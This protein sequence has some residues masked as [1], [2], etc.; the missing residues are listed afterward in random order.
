[1]KKNTLRIALLFIS[2][3]FAKPLAFSQDVGATF[4][5][6][7]QEIYGGHRAYPYNN[8]IVTDN[9]PFLDPIP[10]GDTGD[11]HRMRQWWENM[12]EEINYSGLDFVA[13]LS[14]GNQKPAQKDNGNG[15]PLHIQKLVAA[16]T[17]RGA[18]NFKLAIFDDCPNSWTANRNYYL[19]GNVSTSPVFDCA[20]TAN[21]KYIW[22]NNLRQAIAAIPD[23]KRYKID[24]RM[25]I[26]FWSVKPTWMKNTQ[27]NLTKIL[28]HIRTKCQTEF[29]F[30]P[31]IIIDKDWL[32]NDTT[33]STATVDAVQGWF[34]VAQNVGYT[35]ETW[36]GKKTGA[37]CPGFG[38]PTEMAAYLDPGMGTTDMGKRLKYGLDNT[39]DAGA[40][41]TLVEGFTDSAEAAALWRSEDSQYYDYPNQRLNILRRYTS[42]PYP[43]TLKMEAEACDFN[44]DLTG[45]N[46]GGAFLKS[47]NLDVVDCTDTNG[48]WNVTDTQ[49]NEWMEWRELPLL[50]NTKFQLRY[51]STA[52]SSIKFSVDGTALSTISLPSTSGLWS[53]FDAGNYATASNS[54]HTVKLTIV[55]GSPDINY[56]TRVTGTATSTANTVKIV[57]AENATFSGA[58]VNTNQ[59]G[60]NGTGFIDFVNNSADYL[61]WTVNVPTAGTY[62]LSFRYALPSGGRQLELKVN[63]T[64]KI[65][66]LDF[67]ATATWST[68]ENLSTSQQ[69]VAGNNTIRLTTI[70]SNGGNFDELVVIPFLDTCDAIN[71]WSSAAANTLTYNTTD[72]KQGAGSVQMVGSATEEFKKVFS[73]AFNSGTTVANGVLSFWYFIS[74]VTKT[75]TV[76]VELGSG[77][78][79]DVNELSWGLTGLT[80]GWNKINLNFSDASQIGTA[81]LNA[82]NW[83]RIFSTKTASITTRIDDIQ[84]VTTAQSSIQRKAN[85]LSNVTNEITTPEEKSIRI[86][87]NPYKQ[88]KLTVDLVGFDTNNEFQLQITNLLGQVIHQETFK[89]KSQIEL[90]LSGQLKLIIGIKAH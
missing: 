66:S 25:V 40:R 44:N 6:H 69:L 26:F 62:D 11:W 32:P 82:L 5:W 9:L 17:T 2:F 13:L 79:A 63:G 59:T 3:F 43:A 23:A 28:T 88:G 68:W 50:Q 8:S 51:K 21:Y 60:Y 37:L 71:G 54:L 87:P 76:S 89:D 4:C 48:G 16:M 90:N 75:G 61:Q 22:D 30:V 18:N 33:L 81:N 14:R 15:N 41:T 67:P 85:T 55:S 47:G 56:F 65:A 19:T 84:I 58:I 74:D 72:K 64:V 42:D 36:N 7:Y 35:L 34:N 49:A 86:Y 52:A 73:P 57:Q 12:V 78:A 24:G 53:T 1:M 10:A 70:G 45:T 31:Y 29:G 39:V 77:G 20:D 80:N 83:V 38:K 46:T 27:G